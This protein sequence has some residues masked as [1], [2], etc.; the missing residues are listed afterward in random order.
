MTPPVKPNITSKTARLLDLKKKT[1]EAPKAVNS[2]VKVVAI[3]AA[4][5]GPISLKNVINCSTT[6]VYGKIH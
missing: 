5:T 3:K 2:Q 4:Y 1:K 6:Q